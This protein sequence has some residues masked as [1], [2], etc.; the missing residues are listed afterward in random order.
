MLLRLISE[1]GIFGVSIFLIIMVKCYVKRDEENESYHWLIS[2]GILIMILLNLFR[3]GHYFLNGFPFFVLL[4]IY[5][6]ISYNKFIE[7]KTSATPIATQE[8]K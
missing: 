3:Q 5:N 7:E 4:Y 2:N 6:K 1:T 8:V